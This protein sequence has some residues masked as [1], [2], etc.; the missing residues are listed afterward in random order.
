MSE[1]EKIEALFN[2]FIKE[3]YDSNSKI[4]QTELVQ[5]LNN[6]S[7]EGK[8]DEV[9]SNKLFQILNFDSENLISIK[10]FISGYIQFEEDIR[11]NVEEL[12][13]KLKKFQKEYD[14]LV[15]KCKKYKEEKI[16]SE[17]LCENAKISGEITDID[18]QK[19][20]KGIKEIII[21]VIFNDKSEEFHFQL[22][23][24]NNKEIDNKKFEF[25]PTSRKD[26]F[27]FIMQGLNNKDK[28]FDIGRKVFPLTD[29]DQEEYLVKII[30]PE[31]ENEEKIAAYINAKIILYWNDYKE[32][33]KQKIKIQKKLNKLM[34]AVNKANNYLKK[35]REI[36]G[37]LSNNNINWNDDF[38]NEKINIKEEDN[39]EKNYTL[40]FNNQK[41]IKLEVEF[42]NIKEIKMPE[43]RNQFEL[44]KIKIKQKNEENQEQ[45]V[46]EEENYEEEN[47]EMMNQEEMNQEEMN[48]ENMNQEEINQ[49]EM[50]QEEINQEEL[51]NQEDHREIK[52]NENEVEL[53][54]EDNQRFM[55]ITE[56]INI[57]KYSYNNINY[58]ENQQ[59]TSENK[60]I[61]ERNEDRYSSEE[62]LI[63]QS[64]NKEISTQNILPQIVQEK[65]NDVIYD[66]NVITLPVIYGETKVTYLKEGDALNFDITNLNE[67]Q[68]NNN[69]NQ[70]SKKENYYEI[71]QKQKDYGTKVKKIDDYAQVTEIQKQIKGEE[72][73]MEVISE[74]NNNFQ[75]ENTQEIGYEEYKTT[76]Y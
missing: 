38:N 73:Y 63:R 60:E 16:N 48:Q 69:N 70:I 62:A 10:D 76:T 28:I 33:E 68:N 26:Y 30:V 5:Y 61:I 51:A 17:G 7:S 56:G 54:N 31:I 44:N 2:G 49:E 37:R 34:I 66:K 75:G 59:Q 29:V 72:N 15:E 53:T 57:N 20:M 25:K 6:N 1:K 24:I 52:V 35:I 21:K 18:I 3:G 50:N 64:I 12:N 13:I 74:Y 22:G 47:Q 41:S 11:N 23:D 46:Q 67:E 45:I 40:E 9:I 71:N 4:N 65:V 55:G 36:L 27:E 39:Q 42:N 43:M 32:Y 14:E 58:V 19:K 8:F